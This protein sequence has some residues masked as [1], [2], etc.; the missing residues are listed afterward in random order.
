MIVVDFSE[1]AHARI[2]AGKLRM[3]GL[4]RQFVWVVLPPEASRT[5]THQWMVHG[6]ATRC[7]EC[8]HSSAESLG[9]VS[10]ANGCRHGNDSLTQW[11]ECSDHCNGA[12]NQESR[13]NQAQSLRPIESK[14][15]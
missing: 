13:Y 15:E 1:V 6:H 9:I 11:G 10:R 5:D 3:T 8:R 12:H 7:Q 4:H 14:N 2:S